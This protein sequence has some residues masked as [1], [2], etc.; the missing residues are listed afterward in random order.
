LK[1]LFLLMEKTGKKRDI[2]PLAG[3]EKPACTPNKANAKGGG[4]NI[5]REGKLSLPL[6][7]R[8]KLEEA[9][10]VPHG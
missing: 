1:Y 7:D 6:L 10:S 3:A 5:R 8:T 2:Q 9:R 4:E